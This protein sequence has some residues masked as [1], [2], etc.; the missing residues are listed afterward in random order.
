MPEETIKEKTYLQKAE[1]TAARIEKANTEL[2]ELLSRQ[3]GLIAV[4]RLNGRSEAGLKPTPPRELTDV[5][6]AAKVLAG[7]INPLNV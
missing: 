2:K 3:E 1:E 6:Y 4:E 5:E 7:E